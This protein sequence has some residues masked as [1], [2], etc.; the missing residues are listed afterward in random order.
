[1]FSTLSN[2]LWGSKDQ[3]T[4]GGRTERD[5]ELSRLFAQVGTVSHGKLSCFYLGYYDDVE[6][7]G[8]EGDTLVFTRTTYNGG[9]LIEASAKFKSWPISTFDL[10]GVKNVK[11]IE[12][13]TT[14]Q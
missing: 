5:I 13:V 14:N 12:V 6:Y 1:M 10:N 4:G 8:K 3:T 7:N 11:V 9:G 2:L